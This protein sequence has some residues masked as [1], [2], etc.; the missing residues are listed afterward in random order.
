[1]DIYQVFILSCIS[2]LMVILAIIILAGKGDW[3][4]AGYNTASKKEQ[5]QYNI[6]RLRIVVAVIILFVTAFV[7]SIAWLND[8]VAIVF[9]AMPVLFVGLIAGIIIAN[10][11]CK[12]K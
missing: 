8:T 9:G 12:K 2:L 7:W 3:L 10:T 6:M 4:I 5:E 1:M 11:W